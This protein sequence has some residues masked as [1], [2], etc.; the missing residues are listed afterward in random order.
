MSRK[1]VKDKEMLSL[2]EAAAFIHKGKS[3][4]KIALESGELPGRHL[5][6]SWRIYKQDLIDWIR[7]GNQQAKVLPAEE[8][9]KANQ[10]NSEKI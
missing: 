2:N 1:I 10:T 5:G 4:V 3:A 9:G 8:V 7:A 6:N